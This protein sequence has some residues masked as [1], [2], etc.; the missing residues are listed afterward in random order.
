MLYD[1]FLNKFLFIFIFHSL[2]AALSM[3][4]LSLLERYFG[5]KRQIKELKW[6]K[7]KKAEDIKREQ[8]LI[9]NAKVHIVWVLKNTICF[10]CCSLIMLSI[11]IGE[12]FVLKVVPFEYVRICKTIL[13]TML[14]LITML[15]CKNMLLLITM[16]NV[17]LFFIIWISSL[18]NGSS[19]I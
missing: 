16:L 7:D 2:F 9:N 15:I 13:I 12:R 4:A 1:M 19:V 14:L 18:F 8:T 17:I 6:K 3:V 11:F 5:S 10:L